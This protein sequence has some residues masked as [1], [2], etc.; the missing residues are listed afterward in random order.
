MHVQQVEFFL[1]KLFFYKF[2]ERLTR[3]LS[4][5]REIDLAK[6]EVCRSYAKEQAPVFCQSIMLFLLVKR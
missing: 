1:L 2:T 6:I 3:I 4:I 5:T